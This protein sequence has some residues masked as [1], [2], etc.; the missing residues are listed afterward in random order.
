M[1]FCG[2]YRPFHRTIRG[3]GE[4]QDQREVTIKEQNDALIGDD[5]DGKPSENLG[6]SSEPLPKRMLVGEGFGKL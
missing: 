5:Q 6:I 2:R 3:F 4:S 1:S